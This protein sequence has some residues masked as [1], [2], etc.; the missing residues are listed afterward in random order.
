MGK[1]YTLTGSFK[2][3]IDG[4]YGRKFPEGMIRA[5]V[6]RINEEIR[7]G[8]TYLGELGFVDTGV[9]NISNIS[10]KVLSIN[11]NDNLEYTAD[12]E[13]LDTPAGKQA[14]AIMESICI[15]PNFRGTV[16]DQDRNQKLELTTIDIVP[17][18]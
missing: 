12:V 7:N 17:A 3:L 16:T 4:N 1:I 10:H 14:S 11:L 9:I 8:K 6:N 15:K 5:E 2:G 18:I 13:L